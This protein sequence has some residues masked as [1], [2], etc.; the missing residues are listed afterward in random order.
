MKLDKVSFGL[1]AYPVLQAADILLYRATHV[2]VG[3]DQ[4]QHL[5][6]TREIA[7]H[8]NQRYGE[9]E[10]KKE[11]GKDKKKTKETEEI[12]TKQQLLSS[13]PQAPSKS[14]TAFLP[15]N[16]PTASSC[17]PVLNGYFPLP[18]TVTPSL[19]GRVMSLR[20]GRS[21][22]SKSAD[23]DASRI[24]LTDTSDLIAGKIR[25]A[26]TDSE[27]GLCYNIEQRAEISNLVGIYSQLTGRTLEDLINDDRWSGAGKKAAFK[28]ALTDELIQLIAPIREEYLRLEQ[29]RAY[30]DSVLKQGREE[31]E[32]IAEETMK[33]VREIMGLVR[34]T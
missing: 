22:M 25:R 18:V 15:R 4:Q 21:K 33:N 6:L 14:G 24:N 5:E 19:T 9:K 31:T 13:V 34:A 1:Y 16:S 7:K 12:A 3:E 20:D 26:V 17:E 11:D 27:D 28:D 23:T 8:F 2:P 10:E 32:S 29:D 30:L